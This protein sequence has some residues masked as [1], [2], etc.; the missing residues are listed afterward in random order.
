V[1]IASQELFTGCVP[2]TTFSKIVQFPITRIIIAVLFLAPVLALDKVFKKAVLSS[3]D[4]N[5]LI[6]MKYVEAAIFFTLFIIAYKLYV[7]YIEKRRAIELSGPGW[8]K[9]SGLGFLTSGGLIIVIVAIFYLFGY[10]EIT[11][12]NPVKRVALDLGAKFIMGALLEEI[13]FRLIM[14]KLTEELLGT[15]AALIIQA[16]FFGFAHQANENATVV[17]SLSLIIVGGLF[18]SAAFMCTKRIWFVFGIHLGWNYFQSGLFSMPNSGT[19][20][21]GLIV[22]KVQGPANITGGSFGVEASP[23]AIILCFIAGIALVV[24]A[25][26]NGQFIG[27]IWKRKSASST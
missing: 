6:I 1:K 21:D 22:T 27:P 13:F 12:L 19:P 10:L 16:V 24:K 26:K 25:Y 23:I 17:T 14:Y 9:E 4:G 5:A 2:A 11:G 7:K 15:W 8:F 20:Y 3:L 18:Y